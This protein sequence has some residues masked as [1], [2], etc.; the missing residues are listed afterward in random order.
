MGLAIC[1]P[2]AQGPPREAGKPKADA[3]EGARDPGV[4]SEDAVDQARAH[5]P[6]SPLKRVRLT[7]LW[8][9]KSLEDSLETAD[10]QQTSEETRGPLGLQSRV[11]NQ[12]ESLAGS[13][14]AVVAECLIVGAKEV[15]PRRYAH[16]YPSV[17]CEVVRD[18]GAQQGGV[19]FDMFEDV[20]Q[21]HEVIGAVGGDL[22]GSL[23]TWGQGGQRVRVVVQVDA[24]DLR[25]IAEEWHQARRWPAVA[26]AHVQYPNVPSAKACAVQH[27]LKVL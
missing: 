12:G 21:H 19:V 14:A 26:S 7:R 23:Y 3:C 20:E 16:Q 11:A 22:A 4:E 2:P 9:P 1:R 13:V 17:V 5:R 27:R 8:C 25:A 15:G 6:S 18:Q 10:E 24:Q